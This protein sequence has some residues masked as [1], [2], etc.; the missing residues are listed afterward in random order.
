MD[1]QLILEAAAASYQPTSTFLSL[2]HF[3]WPML[4]YAQFLRNRLQAAE[5]SPGR[6][7]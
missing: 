7:S 2:L 5:G 1:V 6:L 3:F 4:L